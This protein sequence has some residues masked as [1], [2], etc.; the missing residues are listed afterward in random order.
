MREDEA[1][2]IGILACTE[3]DD[4]FPVQWI[5]DGVGSCGKCPGKGG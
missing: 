4:V 3:S 2:F 1:N 5:S